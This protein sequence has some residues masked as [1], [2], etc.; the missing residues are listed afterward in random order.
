MPGALRSSSL[1]CV[2]G[3]L[4]TFVVAD[5]RLSVPFF[6]AQS[7]NLQRLTSKA[8]IEHKQPLFRVQDVSQSLVAQEFKYAEFPEQRFEQPLVSLSFSLRE[9]LADFFLGPFQQ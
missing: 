9:F 6:G 8:N 1:A 7:I 4:S 2:L 3:L 5:P